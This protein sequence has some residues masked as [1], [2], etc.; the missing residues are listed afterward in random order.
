MDFN[1]RLIVSN[2]WATYLLVACFVIFALAK[3]FYPKRFHEF[4]LLPFNNQYFKYDQLGHTFNMML[5]ACQVI[6]VSIFIHLLFMAYNPAETANNDWL[7]IQICT[8]YIVFV[9]IKFSLEKI[10]GNIFSL[11]EL[12]NKYLYQKLSYRNFLGI[13]FFIG[14]LFF[15]YAFPPTAL[16]LV[17]FASIMILLNASTL[18][19]SYKKKRKLIMDNFFYFILYL[20]TLEI[21]PYIILYKS[22]F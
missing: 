4:S 9:L 13:L 3:Y 1:Q 2:D 21:A 19:Y 20:C 5:F 10:I 15:L 16:R 7:F 22:L 17:I 18:F 6:C 12:I 8:G 11:D 14:N